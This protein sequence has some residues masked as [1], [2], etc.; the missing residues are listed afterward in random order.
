MAS[1]AGDV[2]QGG[3]EVVG[4]DGSH[5][6]LVTQDLSDRAVELRGQPLQRGGEGLEAG[7]KGSAGAGILGSSTGVG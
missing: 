7:E 6:V 1:E 2:D 5:E 3:R 4:Q